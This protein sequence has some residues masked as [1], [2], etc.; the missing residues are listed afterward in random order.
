MS[1][2]HAAALDAGRRA[3]PYL[4]RDEEGEGVRRDLSSD[5]NL[6]NSHWH[7]ASTEHV[8]ISNSDSNQR[9]HDTASSLPPSSRAQ[10]G[11]L[12]DSP[13][14]D[15]AQMQ[16]D[17]C[18]PAPQRK[19][20]E[21][22]SK[23]DEPLPM[24]VSAQRMSSN[25]AA[26]AGAPQ[27]PGSPGRTGQPPKHEEGSAGSALKP[28]AKAVSQ[29]GE[30]AWVTGFRSDIGRAVETP[31]LH[32]GLQPSRPAPSTLGV[33][34][35]LRGTRAPYSLSLHE[36]WAGKGEEVLSRI[37]SSGSTPTRASGA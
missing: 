29:A 31:F 18:V 6:S 1:G 26:L 11:H 10:N 13:T 37:S 9:G 24:S 17:S 33:S 34:P 7:G 35:A 27:L 16:E 20:R 28:P 21:V 32:P 25:P 36:G 15:S 19:Q 8:T 14:D 4:S 12:G 22:Q 23:A 3:S 5:T 2:A 30:P